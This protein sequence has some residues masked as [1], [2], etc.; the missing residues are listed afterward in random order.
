MEQPVPEG[1]DPGEGTHTGAVCEELEPVGNTHIRTLSHGK[2]P[3]L[4]QGKTVRRKEQ[5]SQSNTS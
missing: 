3:T 2:D 4:K 5:Q 1:L